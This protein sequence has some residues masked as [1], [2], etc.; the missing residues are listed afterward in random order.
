MTLMSE[1]IFQNAKTETKYKRQNRKD[2]RQKTE[3]IHKRQ[4]RALMNKVVH[5][6]EGGQGRGED[7]LERCHS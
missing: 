1:A 3:T 2:K 7:L 5:Q 6:R 4:R